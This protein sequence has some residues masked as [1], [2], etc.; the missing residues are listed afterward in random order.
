MRRQQKS[1]YKLK[2]QLLAG[3]YM[4]WIIGFI[5]LPLAFILYYAITTAGGGFTF[6]NIAAIADPVHVKSILLSFIK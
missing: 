1:M 5:L 4:V 2:R 6:A 3:P